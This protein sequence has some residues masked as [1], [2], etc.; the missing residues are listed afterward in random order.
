MTALKLDDLKHAEELSA[1][2]MS[3]IVGGDEKKPAGKPIH[4]DAVNNVLTFR[5]GSKWSMDLDGKLHPH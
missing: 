1:Q 3:R 5:D 2:D 4:I